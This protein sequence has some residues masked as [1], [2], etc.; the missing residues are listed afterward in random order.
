MSKKPVLMLTHM[1][2]RDAGQIAVILGDMGHPVETARL[3]KGDALPEDIENYAGFASFGGAMSA[4]DEHVDFIRDEIA[5][6]GRV[7]A[8]DKP[9]LGLCLGGQLM[10]RALGARVGPHPDGTYEF[11]YYP[12]TPIEGSGDLQMAATLNVCLRHGEAFEVPDGAQHL[13][14]GESFPNMAFRYGA[15]GFAL[16][17]HP[18]VNDEILS[19][20]H[21]DGPP[22]DINNPGAQS[23]DEQFA[24]RDA[25]EE[26]MHDWLR[27]FLTHWLSLGN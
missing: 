5:W 27:K 26:A 17:F 16:Q 14:T 7:M 11:G 15:A 19:G 8:A 18:E 3:N 23:A 20:W 25:H 22:P 13:A 2:A 1:A 4:N 24:G 12:V 21:K 6:M 10:A 9:L